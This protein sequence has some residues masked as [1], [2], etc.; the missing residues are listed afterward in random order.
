MMRRMTNLHT[1]I[2]LKGLTEEQ[3]AAIFK[4]GQEAVVWALLQLS[5]L[6]RT[7]DPKGDDPATPSAMVAPYRKPNAPRKGRKKKPGRKQG[8]KGERREAPPNI[9]RHES[10]VLEQCPDCGGPLTEPRS[11][12][13]RVIEDIEIDRPIATEHTIASHY[14]SHCKRRVEPKV[15]DALPKATIGNRTV[16]MTSWFHY[17]LGTATSQVAQVLRQHLPFQD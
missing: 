5:A 13:T 6:A 16:A 1:D 11:T 17:G 2:E 10:H 4:Q 9:E 14:C 3:A 15:T 12:R 7:N 8:H